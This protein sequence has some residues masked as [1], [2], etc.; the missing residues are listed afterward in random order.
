MKNED[1]VQLEKELL[2]K[3]AGG[4]KPKQDFGKMTG[5]RGCCEEDRGEFLRSSIPM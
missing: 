4:G 5:K 1:F 3:I 2:D